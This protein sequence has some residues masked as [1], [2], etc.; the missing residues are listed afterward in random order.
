MRVVR[1]NNMKKIGIFTLDG[2]VNFGNRLQNY[3]VQTIL[4]Q[5]GFSV[6]TIVVKD[7]LLKDLYRNI[8]TIFIHKQRA[9]KFISFN[10]KYI[11]I[12]KIY[13]E[14]FNLEKSFSKKY[15]YFI[16]GSDQ[17]W[18]PN[19][20]KNQRHIFFLDFAEKNQK[21][22]VS[23]SFS[24]GKIEGKDIKIY[25]DGLESFSSISVREFEGAQIVKEICGIDV[26]AL[27][28]PT[29]ALEKKYWDEL[30]SL[31]KV[32]LPKK[33]MLVYFLGDE[34]EERNKDIID[35]AIK[36]QLEVVNISNANSQIARKTGPSEF[37]GL[38][39]NASLVCTDSFH[40]VA[41]SIIN[42]I[43]F[44]AFSR[45]SVNTVAKN[46]ESRIISLQKKLGMEEKVLDRLSIDAKFNDDYSY[47]NK[48]ISQESEKFEDYIK[49]SIDNERK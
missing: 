14:N 26:P 36:N 7:N 34:S 8:R 13:R 3:A 29:L 44:F 11:N 37:I 38:I 2:I 25:K 46:M 20:R 30:A 35:Y 27:C 12:K 16:V 5:K 22:A 4:E 49:K 28:D 31:P 24:V 45:Y 40:G 21:V 23:A 1:E 9:F 42:N 19:I 33:Y 43:P 17:V 47:V 10:R 48:R 32:K 18:N 6:N 41:F 15:D 39:K